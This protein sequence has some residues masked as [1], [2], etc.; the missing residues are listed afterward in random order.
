MNLKKALSSGTVWGS[1]QIAMNVTI[2]IDKLDVEILPAYCNYTLTNEMKYDTISNTFV[3][4]Y[5]PHN[6]I[7]IMH[8]AAGI[9][10]GNNDMRINKNV[11]ISIET[12]E[13]NKILKSLRY[14]ID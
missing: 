3:E 6:K 4:P 10:D 8:L 5:L 11:K 14:G 12:T 13:G 2:Y 9:W 1:E 7:G